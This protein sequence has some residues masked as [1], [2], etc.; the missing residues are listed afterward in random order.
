MMK[1][2]KKAAATE[3]HSTTVGLQRQC[4]PSRRPKT[5]TPC[6]HAGSLGWS[7]KVVRAGLVA[8][9]AAAA[10]AIATAVAAA[11][12]KAAALLA[13][14]G[15]I[16]GQ[17]PIP[18]GISIEHRDGLLRLGLGRH[19]HKGKAL[20]LARIAILDQRAVGDGARLSKQIADLILGRRIGQI[21]DVKL[22]FHGGILLD[23]A[24]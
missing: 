2:K 20:G 12:A 21:A 11:A 23:R 17:R 15:R 3:N 5:K 22:H 13:G 1:I 10:A 6:W 7:A 14:L 24:L 9:I 18:K 8:A 16:H 4:G 19:G